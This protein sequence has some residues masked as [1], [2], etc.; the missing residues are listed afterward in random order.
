MSPC[1][2]W[3]TGSAWSGDQYDGGN[4]PIAGALVGAA[5]QD[6]A[7]GGVRSGS[8]SCLDPDGPAVHSYRYQRTVVARAPAVL[9]CGARYRRALSASSQRR[10][11]C[12]EVVR[13]SG[14]PRDVYRPEI[15]TKSALFP[16]FGH[17]E[18]GAYPPG[19]PRPYSRQ[20]SEWWG[21]RARYDR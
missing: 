8:T 4:V 12:S 3:P 10:T 13:W 7:S 18:M 9:P 17:R 5:T 1:M 2:P 6:R 14:L 19:S 15:S 20:T 16:R 21:R 11:E